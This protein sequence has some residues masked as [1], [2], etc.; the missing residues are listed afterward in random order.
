MEKEF[1]QQK[2]RGKGLS[3]V[4]GSFICTRG[5]GEGQRAVG[6]AAPYHGR[7]LNYLRNATKLLPVTAEY[8]L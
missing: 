1:V 7:L 4:P 6:M 2:Q 3:A 5:G 8:L